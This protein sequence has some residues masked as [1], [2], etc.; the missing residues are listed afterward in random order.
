MKD[1]IKDENIERLDLEIDKEKALPKEVETKDIVEDNDKKKKKKKEKRKMRT[2]EKIFF[3]LNLLIL[4]GIAGYYG[5]RTIYYYKIS[6][7]VNTDITIKDK[8]LSF[9]NV[10]Y[11]NDGL[12][13]K[14]DVY[15]FKGK[16]V[17]NYLYFSGRMYRIIE[18]NNG[19]K[20][21]E[22]ETTTN[23]IWSIDTGYNE[24]NI[25]NWLKNNYINSLKD[26]EAFLKENSWCNEA[27]DIE[28]YKCEE[29]TEDF[30]GL[31]STEEYLRAGGKNS[32]L[33]NE[34]YFWTINQDED[35][36]ALY[37]NNE[38]T[39]NNLNAKDE[40][41][42]S[43][44]IRGV[45]TLRDDLLLVKGEGTKDDPYIVEDEA[46]V[47]IKDKAIGSYVKF[48][49]E[50]FRI[51]NIDDDGVELIL[52]GVLDEQ[53]GYHDAIKY[54]NNEYVKKFNIDNLVKIKYGY[55]EYNLNSKYSI[56][57]DKKDSYYAIIPSIGDLFVNEYGDYW[58]SNGKNFIM[59]LFYS[60]DENEM[61]FADLSSNTHKIRP[62]IKVKGDLIIS[63]GDGTL[64]SPY[65]IGEE[66]VEEN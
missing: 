6:H 53:R 44:G 8:L 39:I 64:N 18:I 29:K 26:Y 33:N 54:L 24:S 31:L 21:I 66:N 11:Q 20:A 51:L 58:L 4:L 47:L 42:Y 10:V 14:G 30:V 43:Y 57:R 28:N 27:V 3:I 1:V 50:K 63:E 38:G 41:Y 46:G 52:D 55:S 15:Y 2:G 36:K 49:D 25:Y 60:I 37:V 40:E 35:H 32:Y 7:E 23:L 22:E 5:Y 12:Y 45:I 19:I 59:G 65:V 62:I 13:E 34:T 9:G 17:N 16:D 56:E 48:S 61:F